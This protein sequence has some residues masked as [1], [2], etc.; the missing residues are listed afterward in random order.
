MGLLPPG[1]GKSIYTS[2]VFPTHVMGRFRGTNVIVA[3][4]GS[5][6][7]RKFGRRARS[8]T[9]QKIYQRIFD[10]NL[11]EE[12]K[13]ADEWALDNG[14]EWMG[15]GILTGI[16]G[17]RGDGIIWD[18]LLKGREQADSPVIRQKTWDAY[19]DDLLTRKKPQAWEIGVTC[20]VG[21]T[22]V[23]M[24]D[25]ICKNLSDIERGDL[26]ASYDEGKIIISKVLNWRNCGPDNVFTMRTKSGMSVTAN[27]R[28]PFLVERKG[29]TEWV[30]L[31]NISVGDHVLRAIGGSGK[32]SNAKNVK[33]RPNVVGFATS[34]MESGDGRKASG[35]LRT[36]TGLSVT[37]I[38]DTVMALT[39][40]IMKQCSRLKMGLVRFA[41]RLPLRATP[42]IGNEFFALT[43]ATTLEKSVGFSVIPAITLSEKVSRR[44]S[45]NRRSNTYR[46]IPDEIISIEPAGYEDVFDV[47]IEHTEN[48]IA[49]GLIS[50]NTRWHEDDV[51]GRILPENYNGE[52]GLIHCRDDNDWYVVCLPAECER[53][54][55][56]LGR[57]KGEILWPEWFTPE[58]F[59][60]AK[61]NPRTWSSLYQ[62]RPSPE[63]GTLFQS[64]WLRPYS[65]N[66]RTG[67]PLGMEIGDLN[68]YGASDYAV[69]EGRENFTVHIVVGVDSKDNLY[70]L[71]LWRDQTTSDVWVEVF[72]NM[73]QQWKPVGWAE[74]SG[75]INAAVG[76]FLA[77]RM[78]ERNV[79]IFRKQ[80]PSTK[81]KAMRAQSI[82]GRMSQ[83]GL[84][85]PFTA[86]WFTEFRREL[87]L[88]DA[89][90]NDD[91]VDALG[92][93]GQILDKMIPA[94]ASSG[95]QAE[96]K[97]FSTMPG[98][99]TVTL[100]DLFEANEQRGTK[101]GGNLRIN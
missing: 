68:I 37:A 34:I 55:D 42:H 92:L 50:H 89:G 48:F 35:L 80:F 73:V 51:A 24:H 11:S 57:A 81:S 14:S 44:E 69:T 79:H 13:A 5:E 83:K 74:E 46:V 25:G 87:L 28:H 22:Q 49:N 32:T 82:I 86:P 72:C 6:L 16:T 97:M 61:H 63:T 45:L 99:C 41:K 58:M 31:Q 90:K 40:P 4:Y 20:M 76:P 30:R 56:L 95:E 7:P 91:Q 39:G 52:S 75:Q 96:P 60:T 29:R 18:D 66:E 33:D 59:R 36:I 85:C 93:I 1:S 64:E 2:V 12:S 62:Q 98:Q 53:D 17:N 71:D 54:D 101:Y 38:C 70:L 3:S 88:F 100:E 84:H 65:Q 19:T 47:Q 23:L 94:S 77:K 27:S 78:R 15:A 21:N 9:Q 8:I 67:M 10:A 43:T 26:V